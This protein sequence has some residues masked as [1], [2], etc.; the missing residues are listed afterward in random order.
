MRSSHL[1]GVSPS[2]FI[3]ALTSHFM[4][5]GVVAATKND[6]L[7]TQITFK[8]SFTFYGQCVVAYF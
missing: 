5:L 2:G 4:L 3:S 7:H 1:G 6:Q 8:G